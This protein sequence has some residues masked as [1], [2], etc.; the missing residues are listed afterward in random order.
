MRHTYPIL[1][2]DDTAVAHIEPSRLIKSVD[3]APHCVVC[4]FADVI[5]KV[6]TTHH[7]RVASIHTSEIGEHP[8]YEIDVDGRRLA[9]FHPGVGAPLAA[10][11]LEEVIAD[12]CRK[13]VACGGAGVLV[14]GVAVGHGLGPGGAGGGERTADHYLP[15]ARE[16]EAHPL[17]VQAIERALQR[18]NVPFLKGKTWTTDAIY[19]ETPKKIALR[20]EEGCLTVEMEAAAF[21]AV[22]QFRGVQ[23][24][25]ILYGGDDLSSETWDSRHWNHHASAREKLFWIAAEACL[26]L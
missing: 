10:G 2:H 25:Q 22:A 17:A 12:G 6:V 26:N 3:I 9:F 21:F 8:V 14:P 16:V 18:D 1:E 11:M 15:P 19:R 23:F 24:G 13:F 5:R 20:R 7:A 4:F